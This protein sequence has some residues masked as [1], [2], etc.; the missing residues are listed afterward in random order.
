[1]FDQ[2]TDFF[3]NARKAFEPAVRL[4]DLSSKLASEVIDLQLKIA[5]DA[6]DFA[7]AQADAFASSETPTGYLEAQRKLGA[8]YLERAKSNVRTCV[9]MMSETQKSVAGWTE[10]AAAAVAEVTPLSAAKKAA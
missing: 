6:V 5:V 1:M 2:T 10:E 8:E 4:G 9:D 3:E 7:A